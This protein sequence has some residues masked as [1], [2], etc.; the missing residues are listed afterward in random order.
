[1]ETRERLTRLVHNG[2][3]HFR[4]R[5]RLAFMTINSSRKTINARRERDSIIVRDETL[6]HVCYEDDEM[7]DVD[8]LKVAGQLDLALALRVHAP[9]R[10]ANSASAR[11]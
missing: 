8:I 4:G 9:E 11:R 2:W 6:E 10:I 5:R 1:M 3:R 7:V